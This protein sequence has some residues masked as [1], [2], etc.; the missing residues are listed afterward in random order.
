[1]PTA[2]GMLPDATDLVLSEQEKAH[3]PEFVGLMKLSGLV[4]SY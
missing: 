1:M 3:E 2:Q 4:S